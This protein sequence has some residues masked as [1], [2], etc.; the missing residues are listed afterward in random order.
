MFRSTTRCKMSLAFWSPTSFVPRV[1]YC[2]GHHLAFLP[3]PKVH[4]P[5]ALQPALRSVFAGFDSDFFTM[6]S[7]LL[8]FP[9]TLTHFKD[10]IMRHSSPRYEITEN[11]EQFRLAVDVPG[12]KTDNLKVELEDDGRVMHISGERKEETGK[13]YKEYKFDKRFT[14]RKDLDTSKITAHLSDGVLVVTAPKME[15]LPPAT[16][17][18]AIIQG[19]APALKDVDGK[20]EAGAEVAP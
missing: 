8:G 5:R 4:R 12:M 11:D 19:E 6:P 10:D 1:N 2:G 17:P 14:L 9:P 16:Q 15:S 3:G 18:I 20:K 13:S 7:P